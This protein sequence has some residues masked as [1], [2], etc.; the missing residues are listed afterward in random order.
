[1]SLLRNALSVYDVDEHTLIDIDP[2]IILTQDHCEVCAVS[3]GDLSVAV[4]ETLGKETQII[5]ASPT[6]LEEISGS[7][8][9]V[10]GALGVPGRGEQLVSN[11]QH[12]F[13]DIRNATSKLSKPN[14]VAIEWIEPLM[15]GGNW[16]PEMIEIAGG[17]PHLAGAGKH[18]PWCEWQDI[19][20]LDPDILLIVP[21][22]Y[23]ISK[24]LGEMN[25][26]TSKD[27]WKELTAVKQNS[28]FILDGNHYFNRPGPRIK[29]SVEILAEIFHPE[30]F[31]QQH[32][33]EGWIR[34]GSNSDMTSFK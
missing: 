19:V 22:G 30:L 33:P 14:V 29:D 10:A 9:E 20:S 24:T 4:K 6:N 8:L 1:M 3:Y 34:F 32:K 12:R 25:I 16:M 23:N 28:V 7:F 17:V 18:S 2:D 31:N 15:T 11:I 21:C 13:T 27:Y 26:L 5:S